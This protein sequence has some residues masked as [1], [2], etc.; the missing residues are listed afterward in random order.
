MPLADSHYAI[1]YSTGDYRILR[2]NTPSEGKLAG[3]RIICMKEGND[4]KGFGFLQPNDSVIFWKKFANGQP[5]YRLARIRRAVEIVAKNPK[6]AQMAFALKEGKCA[7]C[8]RQLTV[9][10]SLHA[11]MGPECA[12]KTGWKKTDQQNA[13][14]F[15]RSGGAPPRSV[16]YPT[17][18]A[19]QIQSQKKRA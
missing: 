18:S 13:F 4:F 14:Q 10:A 19:T 17:P 9:P 6:Q 1:V 5:D 3:K 12:G 15:A 2:V 7:R 8:G 11:G 16:S